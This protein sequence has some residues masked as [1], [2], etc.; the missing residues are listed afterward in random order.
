MNSYRYSRT[1]LAHFIPNG[2]MLRWLWSKCSGCD[3][4]ASFILKKTG[5]CSGFVPGVFWVC[6]GIKSRL[7]LYSFKKNWGVF[8]VCVPGVLFCFI[9]FEKTWVCS[10]FVPG[11]L[12][13]L[14]FFF[15]KIW[16]VFRV[17]CDCFIFFWK[18]LGCVLG[19]FSVFQC[20]V[21]TDPFQCTWV[22]KGFNSI[23]L[24]PLKDIELSRV[25]WTTPV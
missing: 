14:H 19:V 2:W 23:V 12:F 4:F 5:V 22:Q 3:V 6:S 16:G 25:C 15:E 1:D 10:V 18:T 24:R 11:V 20:V 8:W 17:C 21:S 13:L 9:S 7:K